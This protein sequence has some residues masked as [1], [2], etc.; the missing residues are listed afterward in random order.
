MFITAIGSESKSKSVFRRGVLLI[1]M[2]VIFLTS[3]FSVAALNRT[4]VIN[5]DGKTVRVSVTGTD[6]YDILADAGVELSQYDVAEASN[7]NGVITIDVTRYFPV[8]VKTDNKSKDR[9]MVSGGTVSDLLKQANVKVT[10]NHIVTPQK[11][12]RLTEGLTVEVKEYK[13]VKVP[14]GTV[15]DALAYA[16]IKLGKYDTVSCKLTD[17]VTENM[18]ISI[19]RIEY[20]NVKTVE[21]VP[22]ETDETYSDKLAEGKTK[23][24]KKGVDGEYTVVTKQTLVNGEVTDEEI[25][26]SELTKEPVNKEVTIGTKKSAAKKADTD[27]ATASESGVPVSEENGVLYDSEGNQVSYSNVLHGSGTAYYAP[28]GSLTAS[29]QEVYVG[30]VAVNPDIIPLGTKLYIVADD[31]FVYGYATA[32]DTGG[33]LYDGSA[34]VD[35]FYYTYDECAEFG[36]RDVSVYILD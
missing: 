24:T 35:V 32:I 13:T 36:R 3:A 31:G 28:A 29:G 6:K 10:D 21:K 7:E 34:I 1:L 11:D 12:T 30:G 4:A 20:K 26:S 22:Y 16:G 2:S 5:V 14:V 33:A 8:Y 18:E 23:V 9:Y 27:S 17:D 15:K 19:T 25:V